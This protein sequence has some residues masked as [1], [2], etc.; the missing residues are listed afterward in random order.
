M[1][2]CYPRC[3]LTRHGLLFPRC[4]LFASRPAVPPVDRQC[5]TVCCS[6]AVRYSRCGLLFPPLIAIASR[7]L[8]PPIDCCCI[9]V[10]FSPCR[11][12]F[13][14]RFAIS[15]TVRYSRR[16]SLLPPRFID[17]PR[18]AATPA[19]PRAAINV[20]PLPFAIVLPVVTRFTITPTL[21]RLPQTIRFADLPTLP[22]KHR[23]HVPS[24]DI[25]A[26]EGM[27]RQPA[28][29]PPRHQGQN[30]QES[31]TDHVPR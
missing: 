24:L 10:C 22:I 25:S 23:R 4:S 20:P 29:A 12:L 11:S 5:V 15:P 3:S 8:F 1:T 18:S 21:L 17:S 16:G 26:N 7:L 9:M 27:E 13:A 31:V 30:P 19:L 14:S 2:C 28:G 6:P